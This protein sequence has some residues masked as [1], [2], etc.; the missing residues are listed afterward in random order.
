MN[1]LGFDT[2]PEDTRVV[3]AMS[4][5]VDSSVTAALLKDQGY[6]VVGITLQL[7]DHGVAVQK[8]GACCAGQDIHDARRVADA[9]GI[10]HYVLDYES[11]FQDSVMEEF[12]DSYLRGETPVPC[13]RCNQTVKF[14][15]L[16]E[17]SQDLGAVALATGHY[18][19][20]EGGLSG[21]RLYRGANAIKDQSYFLF[22]TT[23]EQADYLRFPLGGLTKE[24][25]RALAE[26]YNLA[27]AAKPESQDICFVPN[28][29]YAS[30]IERIRPGA[31]REGDIVDL[32]GKVLG[33]HNGI[34]NYTI[35]QRRGLG[36]AVGDPLYVVRLDPEGNR[37]VVGP[38]EALLVSKLSLREMNWIGDE[39]LSDQGTE[40]MIKVRSTQDPFPAT[41]YGA[42]NG[43]AEVHLTEPEAGVSA[44]QACVMYD[45]D[46][47]LGG[48]WIAGTEAPL[49]LE[50]A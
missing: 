33:S 40:V 27:V 45:G 46:R 34:I 1:S 48:G 49:T 47:L 9:I 6:D 12:A 23:Q 43:W 25:T 30:V 17:T 14:R 5:G 2:A 11:R 42:A 22:A 10:P 39:P 13:V 15:D 24:E 26:K 21:A 36:I 8:K 20:R 19:R 41:V 44:G 37:V 28:G 38:R 35:G 29:N 3:V 31:G 16:L 7:Y 4:G 50:V 18:I 32:S